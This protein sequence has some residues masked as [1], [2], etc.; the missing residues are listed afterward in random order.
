MLCRAHLFFAPQRREDMAEAEGV[1]PRGE[2]R[3]GLMELGDRARKIAL[4]CLEK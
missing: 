3:E 1:C 4:P 2:L